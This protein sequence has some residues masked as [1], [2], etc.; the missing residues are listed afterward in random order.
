MVDDDCA[1][2]LAAVGTVAAV[3]VPVPAKGSTLATTFGPIPPPLL[4]AL[5]VRERFCGERDGGGGEMHDALVV[6]VIGA[7]GIERSSTSSF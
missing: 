2:R 3:P 7:V 5:F 1:N 6:A 4:L